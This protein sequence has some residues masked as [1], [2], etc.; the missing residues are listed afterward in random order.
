MLCLPLL[1]RTILLAKATIVGW[2]D[3]YLLRSLIIARKMMMIRLHSLFYFLVLVILF[4]ANLSESQV[5]N[6]TSTTYGDDDDYIDL[7][8]MTD[9]ELEEICTSRGFEL[10]REDG[11]VYT[12]QDYVDAASEC[13]QIETD[14]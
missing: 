9:D 10:V 14:L 1:I 3:V 7:V 11:Q 12:H 6:E 8:D 5:A 4:A 2:H 13:L